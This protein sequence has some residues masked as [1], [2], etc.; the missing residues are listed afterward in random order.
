MTPNF[1]EIL[2]E[3]SYRVDSGI[4][5]LTNEYHIEHLIDILRENGIPN[6]TE[7]AKTA[8]IHFSQL[9]ET[10][11]KEPTFTAIKNDTGNLSHFG[12][13]ETKNTAIEAGTHRDPTATKSEPET[14][15][16]QPPQAVDLNKVKNVVTTLYG[17]KNG[18]L[19]GKITEG[20]NQVKTDML[21]HGYNG[22][23]KVTGKKPAPGGAGSAFNEI[24]SCEAA[25]ILEKS[26]D[27]NEEELTRVLISQYCN[28]KLGQEQSATA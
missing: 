24:L 7:L 14:T 21:K 13:E 17:G 23:Q 18:T 26:P 22:Y 20:D 16:V 3:L 10:S 2:L 19:M 8:Q 11:T 6:A 15:A 12:S 5:D 9:N 1:E 25:K 28:T 27:L 4:P